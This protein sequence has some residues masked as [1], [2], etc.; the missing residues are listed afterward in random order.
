MNRAELR[1]M[2]KEKGLKHV[3]KYIWDQS[4][5][6]REEMLAVMRNDGGK[7]K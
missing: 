1:Q 5:Y 3:I 4:W 7:A 2:A 6:N